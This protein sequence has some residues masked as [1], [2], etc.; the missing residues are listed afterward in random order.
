M[1][2]EEYE[3]RFCG[4]KPFVDVEIE[5]RPPLENENDRKHVNAA[6]LQADRSRRLR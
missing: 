3:K 4:P 5:G 2:R 6:S 1:S